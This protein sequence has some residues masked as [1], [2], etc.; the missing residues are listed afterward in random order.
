MGSLTAI[1]WKNIILVVGWGFLVCIWFW[2]CFLK[3]HPSF[4]AS[5]SDFQLRL[6]KECIFSSAV[7]LD[8]VLACASPAL[9]TGGS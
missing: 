3:E 8:L 1:L 4:R 6:C 5:S 2:F 9:N 7:M